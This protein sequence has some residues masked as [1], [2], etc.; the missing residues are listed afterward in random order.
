MGTLPPYS[1]TSV[2]VGE[3]TGPSTPS[4]LAA[5]CTKVVFPAPRS[6]VSET[7]SPGRSTDAMASPAALVSSGD[8]VESSRPGPATDASEQTELLLGA[9][10][11]GNR[12]LQDLPH[13]FEVRSQRGHLR[14]G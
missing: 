6:P 5:P 2:N 3:R 1:R 10:A 8:D 11:H 12:L 14:T 13:R 4:A 9:R 7:T